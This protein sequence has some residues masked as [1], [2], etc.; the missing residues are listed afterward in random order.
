MGMMPNGPMMMPP[1]G[2][3]PKM[4][5]PRPANPAL[6]DKLTTVWVGRI[7]PGVG[8]D[9]IKKLLEKCGEVVSW[10]RLPDA[11]TGQ[12]KTFG[13]ADFKNAQGA[14]RAVKLLSDLFLGDKNL[15]LKVDE[16]TQK[17]LD[18]YSTVKKEI[19]DKNKNPSATPAAADGGFTAAELEFD[20]ELLDL[21]KQ[22]TDIVQEYHRAYGIDERK[23]KQRVQEEQSRVERNDPARNKARE[24]EEARR[25]EEREREREERRKER[26][27]REFRNKEREWEGHEKDRE[28]EKERRLMMER[29]RVKMRQRNIEVD[30][31]DD[32][33]HRRK[34]RSREKRRERQR[35]LEEDERERVAELEELDQRRIEEERRQ[36]EER[37][38]REE[39]L[40]QEEEAQRREERSAA[41][42]AIGSPSGDGSG[43]APLKLGLKLTSSTGGAAPNKKAVGWQEL[44]EP[45]QYDAIKKKKPLVPLDFAGVDKKAKSEELRSV[46]EKIPTDKDQLFNYTIDWDVIDQHNLVSQKMRPWIAKKITEYFGEGD[47]TA[48]LIEYICKKISEHSKPLEVLDQLKELL[49][50]AET[51][52]VRMWRMLIFEMLRCSA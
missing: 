39:E 14:L 27:E 12:L 7:T 25:R 10:K 15:Q 21:K 51:F 50:E 8:D 47:E 6:E 17:Y 42:P 46:I 45:E 32:R 41:S 37:K 40:R 22:I 3:G 2:G 35:E 34:I 4:P 36:E 11:A 38:R 31:Q 28:K 49:D 13:F 19:I 18:S 44:E 33:Q 1:M 43:A 48:A 29:E 52:V 23:V 24:E 16:K 20:P 5:P 26:A 30:E 9:A